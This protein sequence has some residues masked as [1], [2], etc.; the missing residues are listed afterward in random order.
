MRHLCWSAPRS[1]VCRSLAPPDCGPIQ[2]ADPPAMFATSIG[3]LRQREQALTRCRS[4]GGL[5]STVAGFASGLMDTRT[6][7]AG[8]ATSSSCR[9]DHI[10]GCE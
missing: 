10:A 3:M 4:V 6:F 7:D 2:A 1:L 5:G 9:R 8:A